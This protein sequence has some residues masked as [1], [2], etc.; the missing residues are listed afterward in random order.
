M[1]GEEDLIVVDDDP[2]Q[3]FMAQS[4]GPMMVS[5]HE[6]SETIAQSVMRH[7]RKRVNEDTTFVPRTARATRS[8]LTGPKSAPKLKLKLSEKAGMVTGTSFLGNYDREL[9]SEDEDLTFEEQFML[10]LPPGEDCEKL[11]KMVA[12]REAHPDVWFKFKG[13]FQCISCL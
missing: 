10:R 7:S 3:H 1:D 6:E 9:D 2:S 12:T 4:T 8:S 11:K 5:D 13:T